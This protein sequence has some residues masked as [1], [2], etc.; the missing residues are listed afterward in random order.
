VAVRPA[1]LRCPALDEPAAVERVRSNV[2]MVPGEGAAGGE[3][4]SHRPRAL[5]GFWYCCS[6]ESSRTH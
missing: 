1:W 6:R 4:R 5:A 2:V 3:R